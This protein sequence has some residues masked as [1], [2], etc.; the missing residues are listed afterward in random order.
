MPKDISTLVDDIYAVLEASGGWDQYTTTFFSEELSKL[1]HRRFVD[2]KERN[3]LSLSSVGTPCKR[4]LWLRVNNYIGEPLSA[5]AQGSFFYGD[6]IEIMVLALAKA[7]GHT[8]EAEQEEVEI[9]GV[10]GHIDAIIDGVLVDLK[11]ASEYG[12]KKFQNH[13]LVE[14]DPFGYISQISS[15][16]YALKDDPRL[17][18]KDR[19]AFLVCRKD[20]FNLCL[21]TYDLRSQLETKLGEIQAAKAMVFGP[22]VIE[23][24]PS[25]PQSKTSPNRKLSVAC[26]YCEYK[27]LCWPKMRT[28]L[29]STGPE[30]LTEVKKEPNVPELIE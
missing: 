6:I 15:Y 17:K 22:E 8:V 13:S 24:I 29:Y 1:A 30:Y 3:Y 19:A 5:Q 21:D 23:R 10:I 26:S 14:D 16:L 11:S 25:I 18:I 28:F 9:D 12:F 20:R 2:R 7:A 4:K 27:K